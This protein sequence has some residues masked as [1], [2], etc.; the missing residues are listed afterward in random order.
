LTPSSLPRH[1]FLQLY[2]I[3]LYYLIPRRRYDQNNLI[4][5]GR[6]HVEFTSGLHFDIFSR[7]GRQMRPHTKFR[8][9]QSIFR[10]VMT[11][12][13]FSRWLP[14]VILNFEK[15]KFCFSRTELK[16]ASAH[17]IWLKSND[18]RPRYCDK[19]EIEYGHRRHVEFTFSLLFDTIEELFA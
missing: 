18:R 19:T 8:A 13:I 14:S 16:S 5:Y 11:F 2:Q 15:F 10:E 1:V 9:S 6:R 7:L 3:W 4:Q 12:R 17:Q